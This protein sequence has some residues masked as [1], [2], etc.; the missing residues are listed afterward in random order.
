MTKI[1]I[2]CFGGFTYVYFFGAQYSAGN[3]F[4][5]FFMAIIRKI[6]PKKTVPFHGDRI[7]I[8]SSKIQERKL[9]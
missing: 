2:I 6:L 3:F 5:A 8:K 7:G 9:K 4:K 1:S